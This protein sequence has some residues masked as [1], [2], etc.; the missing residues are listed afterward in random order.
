VAAV[1]KPVTENGQKRWTFQLTVAPDALLGAI[2][3]QLIVFRAKETGQ[4]IRIPLKGNANG[5]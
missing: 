1:G 3:G 5:L 2:N 4:M